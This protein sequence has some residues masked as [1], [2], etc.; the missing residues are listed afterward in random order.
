MPKFADLQALN[1]NVSRCATAPYLGS[2]QAKQEE[3][4]KISPVT[5]A[6]GCTVDD[7]PKGYAAENKR[8]KT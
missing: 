8:T 1:L 4:L 3:E 6:N 2:L 5:V 7:Y